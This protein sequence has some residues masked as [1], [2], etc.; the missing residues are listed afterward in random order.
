V[1]VLAGSQANTIGGT[2]AAAGN[3]ISASGAYDV[4]VQGSGTTG[5]VVLGN[6]IGLDASGM[7]G[8][9]GT[10][11]GVAIYNG[12]QNNTIGGTSGGSRNFIG[13][14]ANN[15][16]M[17]I[18]DSGTSANMVQGNT[19]GL[20][21]AGSAVPNNP[22]IGFFNSSQGN[23]IGGG[24]AGASNIIAGNTNEGIAV[25]SF[26]T[27]T[28]KETFSRNSIFG[29]SAKGIALYNGGNN[30]QPAPTSLSRG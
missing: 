1:D 20:N 7:S 5:N 17:F 22:G 15:Y 25:Y 11:A 4:A 23:T 27:T 24:A 13:G 8:F 6:Y 19:I 26:N 14:H 3:V 10:N 12:A 16:G 9:A 2:L 18:A 21:I 28:I 30:S 29:N